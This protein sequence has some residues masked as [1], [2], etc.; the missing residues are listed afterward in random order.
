MT[1]CSHCDLVHGEEHR[2]CQVCGQ[3]LK[4]TQ[5]GVRPCARC[6]AHTLPGQKFC[7][8]CG[9]PL[10]VLPAGREEKAAPRSPL[11]YPRGPENRSSRRQRQ[12]LRALVVLALFLVAGLTLYW[13]GK[14]AYTYLA[15]A[16]SGRPPEIPITTPRD[17]LKPTVERLA[18]RI[19]SAHLNK[20]IHKW[21]SCY[22]SNYPNLGQLENSILEL[23]KNNDVKEV[24]YRINDVRPLGERQ[25]SALVTWSIQIYDLRHHDYQLL[26][27]TYRVTLEKVNGD[28]KIL[29]SKEENGAK[30]ES[31]DLIFPW[32]DQS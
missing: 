18:E 8:D 24:S 29:D 5:A 27:Q 28:W 30:A 25:A 17:N 22:T 4:R 2:F 21:L 10:R 16:W 6:G 23:W 31:R 32:V 3:L 1:Y 19:R 26:R 7:T 13:G 11:F 15:G 20:D 14:K 9:L 12:P